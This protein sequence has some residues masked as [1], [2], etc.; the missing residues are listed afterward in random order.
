MATLE[1]WFVSD[2]K[3]LTS[4]QIEFVLD[5]YDDGIAYLDE[6]LQSRPGLPRKCRNLV[7]D[8][9]ELALISVLEDDVHVLEG[10]SV[11]N[12]RVERAVDEL[13]R[14][15][16]IETTGN[17]GEASPLPRRRSAEFRHYDASR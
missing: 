17:D 4:N 11:P 13:L 3:K 16:L 6:Y 9:G 5:A 10:G 7:R 14:H 8:Q 12:E 2:K 1:R 15:G